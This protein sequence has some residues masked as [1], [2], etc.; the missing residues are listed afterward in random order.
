MGIRES[1]FAPNFQSPIPNP[2]SPTPQFSVRRSDT[3]TKFADW[4]DD[5]LGYRAARGV[6]SR[7]LRPAGPRWSLALTISTLAMFLVVAVTGIAL[8][9]GYSP[10]TDHGWSSVFH[11]E[12]TP[13]GSFLR[14]LHYYGSHALIILFAI[15][16][17][18]TILTASF[19][20]PRDL[21]WIAGVLLLPLLAAAAVTG[22]PLTASNKAVGQ[23]EVE[24]HIIG[25]IPLIGP[26]VRELFVGGEQIG[27][28]TMTRLYTLHVMVLPLL[29]GLLLVLHIHQQVRWSSRDDSESDEPEDPPTSRAPGQSARNALVFGVVFAAVAFLAWRFGVP[30]E[31]PADPTLVSMPRPEWYFRALFELRNSMVG[32][33]EF[34]VTGLLPLLFLLLLILLPWIDRLMPG[35]LSRWFRYA[36]VIGAA[37]AWTG[38]TFQSYAHDREDPAYQAF[39]A[40]SEELAKRA[41]ELAVAAE[42]IPPAGPAALLQSDPKIQGPRLFIQHCANCHSHVDDAGNGIPAKTSA[43]SNLYG[44]GS[45]EWIAGLLDP[46]QISSGDYYGHTAF[47]QGFA[48][49]GMIDYVKSTLYAVE[50]EQL[51]ERRKQ[52]RKVVMALSAEAHLPAQRE[53]DLADAEEIAAGRK[54]LAG[55]TLGCVECHKFGEAGE[56]AGLIPA[57]DLTGYGSRA[58]LREF[59]ANPGHKRFY[60][61]SNDGMPAYRP[62]EP[63]SPENILPREELLLIVDWLRGDWVGAHD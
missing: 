35:V 9:T 36:L 61:S 56:I 7:H 5:R 14:G 18:R 15:H 32:V 27:H 22:N 21:A 43:A 2:Q 26:L 48:S 44:F 41:R 45:R 6:L 10:A 34:V 37:V 54:L 47:V 28:L 31:V 58:W 12:S 50:P 55:D 49:M 19:R 53:E 23:I 63:G 59:I 62:A 11:I 57:P 8:M 42:G 25:N 60:G 51:D 38:L 52:V 3:L 40:E 24:S 20:A 16:L 1:R 13:G 46:E 29:A 30:L 4:L 33:G 39:L 17:A